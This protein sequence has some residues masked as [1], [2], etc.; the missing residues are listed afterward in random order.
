MPTLV[1][2]APKT[3]ADVDQYGDYIFNFACFGQDAQAVKIVFF[4][5]SAGLPTY[6]I[7][8]EANGGLG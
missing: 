6:T 3:S 1:V 5:A 4:D 2:S 7:R 8:F